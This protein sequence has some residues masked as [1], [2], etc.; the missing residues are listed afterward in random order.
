MVGRLK[1]KL[2]NL[3]LN[4]KNSICLILAVI[5]ISACGAG[6]AG[7]GAGSPAPA[8]APA[9]GA[10]TALPVNETAAADV[11]MDRDG[12]GGSG[13]FGV[14]DPAI[15]DRM[16]IRNAHI[17]LET[18][19]FSGTIIDVERIVA[20]YGG[21]IESSNQWLMRVRD[22]EFWYADY[23]LRVP[24]DYFDA[25]NRDLMAL[26]TVASFSTTSEDVTMQFQDI[27]SRLRI[28]QEEERRIL[29][30]IEAAEELE[31]LIRLETRLANVRIAMERYSRRMAE[32]DHLAS[33]SAIHLHIIE[34][35]EER[36]IVPYAAGFFSNIAAAFDGSISFSLALLEGIAVLVASVILPLALLAVP[37]L[38]AY[39]IVKKVARK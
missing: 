23:I 12:S 7:Y 2:K 1:L 30:M 38:A 21:F 31:D 17:S 4:L 5:F 26:G 15:L 22:E 33:F 27:E 39:L 6:G 24:V 29:N 20:I 28:R 8:A 19:R 13:L 9:P 25:V 36:E 32:I 18:E 11:M 10:T 16:V 37:A 14:G 35:E 34:V 3:K